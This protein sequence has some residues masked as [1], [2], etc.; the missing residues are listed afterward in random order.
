MSIALWEIGSSAL[1]NDVSGA[2]ILSQ[3][4]A[5]SPFPVSRK[6]SCHSQRMQSCHICKS[7]RAYSMQ[8]IRRN[9][10][11]TMGPSHANQHFNIFKFGNYTHAPVPGMGFPP[12]PA[13]PAGM[14][15]GYPPSGYAYTPSGAMS[16]GAMTPVEPPTPGS[17]AGSTM[18]DDGGTS[19]W[20]R[21]ITINTF[22]GLV[23]LIDGH[24]GTV[25]S[26]DLNR[27]GYHN[28]DVNGQQRVLHESSLQLAKVAKNDSVVVVGKHD[29][30][31]H[32]GI[33]TTIDEDNELFVKFTNSADG[34]HM[35]YF[36]SND[37]VGKLNGKY[38]DS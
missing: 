5:G 13:D 26:S 24:E 11:E 25:V 20:Q 28:V 6:G 30:F 14:G 15:S 36:N 22:R 29:F 27:A 37:K 23:V 10:N 2:R 31:G 34:D 17:M 3:K 33:V 1:K 18:H 19:G 16:T 38:A 4:Y 12:T 7:W 32:R 35:E 9:D 8:H 21:A